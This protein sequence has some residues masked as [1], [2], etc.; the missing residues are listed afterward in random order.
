MVYLR[1]SNSTRTQPYTSRLNKSKRK[2]FV[3]SRDLSAMCKISAEII[4]QLYNPVDATNR[5]I[6]LALQSLDEG[7]Q[8]RQFLIES[9]QG[10]RRTAQLLKRL[11]VNTKRIEKAIRKMSM[12]KK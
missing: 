2:K 3:Q 10:I 4:N 12:S 5:F 1:P 11:N 7:S 8:S 6:N 9:K